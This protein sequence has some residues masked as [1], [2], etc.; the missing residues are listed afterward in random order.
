MKSLLRVTALI[1]TLMACIPHAY[2]A[3]DV[4]SVAV[5]SGKV[6][7]AKWDVTS[8]EIRRLNL[9]NGFALGLKIEPASPEKNQEVAKKL[10]GREPLELVEISLYDLKGAE[11][12]RLSHTWG[13]TNSFQGY[14]PAGGADRVSEVGQPGIEL[15]L[16][17]PKCAHSHS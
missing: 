14:G 9:P 4:Q 15:K 16:S 11:P 2:A 1:S 12:K 7:L 5:S 10:A 3:C 8:P 6:E 13:G 17:K